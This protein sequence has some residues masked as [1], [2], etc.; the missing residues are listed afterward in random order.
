M[1]FKIPMCGYI[2]NLT[3]LARDGYIIYCYGDCNRKYEEAILAQ[4]KSGDRD[5]LMEAIWL[6]VYKKEYK[7]KEKKLTTPKNRPAWRY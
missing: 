4:K 1:I 7:R 2:S 6:E 3:T 5:V